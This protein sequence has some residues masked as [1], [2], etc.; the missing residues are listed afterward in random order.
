MPKSPTLNPSARTWTV[1]VTF[2]ADASDGVLLADGGASFG[3]CLAL[4]DG[5]PVFTVV[6]QKRQTRVAAK[7]K[8]TGAW[9]TVRATITPEALL[10]AVN[11]APPVREPLKSPLSREPREALQIGNDLGSAVMSDQ[12]LPPFRGLIESVRI[13]SGKAPAQAAQVAQ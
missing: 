5:Q 1:E 10:L 13:Y 6:G 3:Y 12:K 2:K 11:G 7:D 9:T 8:V 4:K